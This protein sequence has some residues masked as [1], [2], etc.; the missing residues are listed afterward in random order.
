MRTVRDTS[1]TAARIICDAVAEYAQ[2]RALD[3]PLMVSAQ[4]MA[5]NSYQSGADVGE[6]IEIGQGFL[7]SF[8]RHPSHEVPEGELG[9]P[10]APLAPV[11]NLTR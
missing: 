11:F 6:A 9:D 7:R 4:H 3:F 10:A 5:L 8:L 1:P 2:R